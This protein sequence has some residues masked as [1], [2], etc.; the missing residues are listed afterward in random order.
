M[1]IQK[2]YIM[3]M[4]REK[5]KFFWKVVSHYPTID[6]WIYQN[7]KI[8]TLVAHWKLQK[9]IQY[10]QLDYDYHSYVKY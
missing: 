7:I 9:K 4:Y 1:V 2:I 5:L 6:H 8:Q 10:K 3:E